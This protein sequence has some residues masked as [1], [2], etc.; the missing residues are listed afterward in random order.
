MDNNKGNNCYFLKGLYNKLTV[1]IILG[2]HIYVF[3][4]FLNYNKLS[5]YHH[6]KYS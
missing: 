1:K 4:V 6:K 3:V 2:I 5:C